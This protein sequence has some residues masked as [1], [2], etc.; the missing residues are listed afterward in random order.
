MKWRESLEILAREVRPAAQ[1]H[2][3]DLVVAA[4]G[5]KVKCVVAIAFPIIDIDPVIQKKVNRVQATIRAGNLQEIRVEAENI[6]NPGER[7]LR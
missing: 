7:K 2:F 5:G 3:D 1:E 6:E 4:E